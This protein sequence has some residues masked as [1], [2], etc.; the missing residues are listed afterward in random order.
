MS[1][2]P[3]DVPSRSGPSESGPPVR[4]GVCLGGSFIEV[5]SYNSLIELGD[6]LRDGR[7]EAAV[8]ERLAEEADLVTEML[9][10][11]PPGE[12]T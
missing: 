3:P 6:A 12:I 10:H 11:F 5:G 2:N 8:R 9:I 7:V 4:V 1:H